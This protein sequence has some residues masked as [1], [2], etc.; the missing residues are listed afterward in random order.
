VYAVAAR[1]LR[2]CAPVA[3]Q[4]CPD[5]TGLPRS[6]S[7]SGACSS[8]RGS[9]TRQRGTDSSCSW[10]T[11]VPHRFRNRGAQ[12]SG[13]A[14]PRTFAPEKL[15]GSLNGEMA[16]DKLVLAT[17]RL[18]RWAHWGGWRSPR[19]D[20]WRCGQ[21]WPCC[22]SCSCRSTWQWPDTVRTSA[23]RRPCGGR[24][25]TRVAAQSRMD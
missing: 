22:G 8:S 17:D 20:S 21:R 19:G 2:G 10:S 1:P 11:C 14:W 7:R 3:R 5:S 12:W 6:R 24:P 16:G 25:G 4:S 18:G 9:S 15:A 23:S 13:E